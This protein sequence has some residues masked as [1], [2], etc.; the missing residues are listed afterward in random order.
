MVLHA[1]TPVTFPSRVSKMITGSIFAQRRFMP[2]LVLVYS[3]RYSRLSLGSWLRGLALSELFNLNRK[4]NFFEG[5]PEHK[6]KAG[7]LLSLI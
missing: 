2:W 4:N 7:L 3:R 5:T 6:S 1:H